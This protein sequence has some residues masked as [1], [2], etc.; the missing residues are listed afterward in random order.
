MSAPPHVIRLRGPWQYELAAV[1]ALPGATESKPPAIAP[2]GSLRL[3]TDLYRLQEA[4]WT[5]P[6]TFR[7]RFNRPSG[8]RPVDQLF[9]VVEDAT[10]AGEV[11]LNG[12]RLGV[13]SPDCPLT[14]FSILA[15]IAP[16]NELTIHSVAPGDM[17]GAVWL[18]IR[19]P[20]PPA[21]ESASDN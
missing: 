12:H 5:G 1:A 6:V 3:P 15:V 14:A 10:C 7:R 21:T 17:P 4:G 18:E 9:L 11:S 20:A 16:H 8:I 2:S 19:T 13:L